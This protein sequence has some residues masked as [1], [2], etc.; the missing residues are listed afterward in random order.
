MKPRLKEEDN[1]FR[2][3]GTEKSIQLHDRNHSFHVKSIWRVVQWRCIVSTENLINHMACKR[4]FR[5]IFV[6]RIATWFTVSGTEAKGIQSF[7]RY[8]CQ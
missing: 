6:R 1:D 7:I 3:K 5:P 8:V 4:T 2:Q